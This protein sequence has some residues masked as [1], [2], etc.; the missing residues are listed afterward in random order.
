MM[1]PI[2]LPHRRA[3]RLLPT[4]AVLLCLPL[5]APACD[6]GPE[7]N[8]ATAGDSPAVEGGGSDDT[9]STSRRPGSP[10]AAV[11][12]IRDYYRW[13][14]GGDYERAYRLWSGE[15]AASGQSLESFTRGYASTAW[16]EVETGEP[17]RIE[18]AAGSRYIRIPV[19]IRASLDD[20]AAQCFEGAYALRRSEVDGASAAQR[21]WR[22]HSA[23]IERCA[24]S[25]VASDDASAWAA[26]AAI[27]RFGERL[28][29]VSLLAPRDELRT[30]IRAEYGPLVTP[31]LLAEWLADPSQAPGRAVS[32]PWPA[33]ISVSQARRVSADEY[34]M[35]GHV[36]E[37]ANA[38]DG[39][40]TTVA[41]I[42]VRVQL[43]RVGNGWRVADYDEL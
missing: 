24:S 5:V 11:A 10:E 20:G 42:P 32:S 6:V 37:V 18:G 19:T 17:G 36:V 3:A 7:A 35:T 12:V 14:E 25:A 8:G 1:R 21:A 4:C 15:G 41:R 2:S 39:G 28:S 26:I 16:V 30:R 22:I 40:T 9:T 43:L 29:R 13:I 31:A 27:E 23:E 33:R 38:A 34:E